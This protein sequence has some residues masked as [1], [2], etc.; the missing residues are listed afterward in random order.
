MFFPATRNG[1]E[2]IGRYHF[3]L[4]PLEISGFRGPSFVEEEI[5]T[6][7]NSW[8]FQ[9]GKILAKI[10]WDPSEGTRVKKTVSEVIQFVT[11]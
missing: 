5:F 4:G 7:H 11:F 6:N 8:K 1:Q 9:G 3:L 10:F 2:N